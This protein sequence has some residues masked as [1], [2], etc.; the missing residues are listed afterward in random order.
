MLAV[1][2]LHIVRGRLINEDSDKRNKL[3]F[4]EITKKE[5]AKDFC[6]HGSETFGS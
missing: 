5:N 2:S 1:S 6:S 4:K 3:S